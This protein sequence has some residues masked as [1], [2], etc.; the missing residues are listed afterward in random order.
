MTDTFDK[1]VIYVICY[2][3]ESNKIIK[4][5]S[6]K[7]PEGF[8]SIFQFS[9]LQNVSCAQRNIYNTK[10]AI[11]NYNCNLFNCH[12]VMQVRP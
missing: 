10:L 6:M 4:S 2:E 12:L 8:H 7:L 5:T 9:I 3:A 11:Y 1:S